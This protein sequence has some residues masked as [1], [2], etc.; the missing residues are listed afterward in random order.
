MLMEDSGC[1]AIVEG[2]GE[3]QTNQEIMNRN[4]PISISTRKVLL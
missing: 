3:A 1:H 4:M 2:V